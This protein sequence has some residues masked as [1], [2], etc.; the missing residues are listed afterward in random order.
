MGYLNRP[1]P[2]FAVRVLFFFLLFRPAAFYVRYESTKYR[3]FQGRL[4]RIAFVK[5]QVLRMPEYIRA[6]ND[7]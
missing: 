6:V 1:A 7:Y 5:A 3:Y 4:T 2:G